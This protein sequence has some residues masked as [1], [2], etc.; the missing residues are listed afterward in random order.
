MWINAVYHYWVRETKISM[1][2]KMKYLGVIIDDQWN[3]HEHVLYTAGKAG[4]MIDALT[5]LLPNLR[6]PSEH[7]RRFYSSVVHSVMMYAAPV[8]SGVFMTGRKHWFPL[9]RLQRLIALTV[10]V[11]YRTVSHISSRLLTRIIPVDPC[12][13]WVYWEKKRLWY[14]E[15]DPPPPR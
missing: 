4:A 5:R 11:A 9:M 3:F 6:G 10:L 8:W 2:S 15:L 12:Y 1:C 7:R 13:T 14:E